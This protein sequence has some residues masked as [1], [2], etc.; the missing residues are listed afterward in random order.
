V[1]KAIAKEGKFKA[2]LEGRM[3]IN[4]KNLNNMKIN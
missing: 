4:V 3:E 2:T 1:K